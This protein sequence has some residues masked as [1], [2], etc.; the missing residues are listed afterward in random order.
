MLSLGG[1]C[2]N[3]SLLGG[4]GK[5]AHGVCV[6]GIA[7]HVRKVFMVC[8]VEQGLCVANYWWK[9]SQPDLSDAKRRCHLDFMC[10]LFLC[11][12]KT[13]HGLN[14]VTYPVLFCVFKYQGFP[15]WHYIPYDIFIKN[16]TQLRYDFDTLLVNFFVLS[17]D[18]LLLGLELMTLQLR[19]CIYVFKI[20]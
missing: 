14:Y 16:A 17:W 8:T 12:L 20:V 18:V 5:D 6:L 3:C 19:S 7:V 4:V 15:A 1:Q 9:K 2:Q 11:P 10:P 13:N